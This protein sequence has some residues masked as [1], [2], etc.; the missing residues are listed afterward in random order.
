MIRISIGLNNARYWVSC[1]LKCPLDGVNQTARDS[2]GL[3]VICDC[4]NGKSRHGGYWNC[5][6]PGCLVPDS[7]IRFDEHA[8]CLRSPVLSSYTDHRISPF[9]WHVCDFEPPVLPGSDVRFGGQAAAQRKRNGVTK[10]GLRN[11]WRAQNLM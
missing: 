1:R 8:N 2:F 11:S 3:G 9:A 10:Q 4:T 5:R 7:R 6:F